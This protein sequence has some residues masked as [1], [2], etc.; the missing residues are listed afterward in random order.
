MNTTARPRQAAPVLISL[1][2][3]LA[4]LT[5]CGL[6][7]DGNANGDEDE[8]TGPPGYA[9]PV[10]VE[11]GRIVDANGE[12]VLDV[13]AI[14]SSL[15]VDEDTQFGATGR[16]LDASVSPDKRQLAVVTAGAAHSGGWIQDHDDGGIYPAAF[17]YGG[18]L[19][20]GPWREDGRYLVFIE[21]GPAG[22][23]TLSLAVIERLGPT[24]EASAIAVRR[25]GDDDLSPEQR[26]DHPVEWDG[27]ELV[28]ERDG[29]HWRF[30]AG[31][32]QAVP[33]Q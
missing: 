19:E 8:A 11:E 12:E 7:G 29:E 28:I 10:T 14:P 16:F 31:R 24:L 2:L 22:G 25:D 13:E 5:A 21:R 33:R 20:I 23:Q 6:D 17:Q 1:L 18:E 27:D 3:L 26:I 15:A 30:D 32:E 9:G 4:A